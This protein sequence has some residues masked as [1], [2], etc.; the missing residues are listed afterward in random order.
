M[1]R[2][3]TELTN[4]LITSGQ[5]YSNKGQPYL[6]LNLNEQLLS[7]CMVQNVYQAFCLSA[8]AVQFISGFVSMPR[9]C[10]IIDKPC[11]ILSG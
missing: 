11:N 8:Q 2:I 7:A 1:N 10:T 5:D 6:I 3:K 9:L 4:R